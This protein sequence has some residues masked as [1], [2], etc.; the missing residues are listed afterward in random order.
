MPIVMTPIDL[1]RGPWCFGDQVK[2]LAGPPSERD[3]DACEQLTRPKAGGRYNHFIGRNSPG[4]GF[5]SDYA[6]TVSL[7]A[8]D[9]LMFLRSAAS[10]IVSSG[11]Q[12]T[13][14][15]KNNNA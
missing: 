2:M 12:R 5:N 11:Y 13:N 3:A 10:R 4:A 14:R 9:D 6:V 8:L 1:E 15:V 7:E